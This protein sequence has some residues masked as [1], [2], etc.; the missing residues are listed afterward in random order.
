MK[1]FDEVAREGGETSMDEDLATPVLANLFNKASVFTVWR[2]TSDEAIKNMMLGVASGKGLDIKGKSAKK[3]NIS[4]YVPFIQIYED[5]HKDYMRAFLNDGR[6]VRVFYHSEEA[7]MEAL[8]MIFDIKEYMI[9]SA[10]D[11]MDILRNEFAN[12][13]D[14][15]LAM[16][17]LVYDDTN[18]AVDFV[19]T[20]V[21]SSQPVFG[22]DISERLFWESYVT[23]QD[24]SRPA[25]TEWDIGRGS[26]P[27]YMDKNFKSI[28]TVAKPGEPK[29]VVWQMSK[30]SPMQ[31]R[32]LLIAYEEFGTVKPVV[33]D[34]DCF[35][36]GSRG[37]KYDKP[38]SQDQVELTKWTVRNIGKV[39]DDRATSG[40]TAGWMS[41]WFK[42]QKNAVL[43]GYS[44]K[45]PPYGHGDP[46]SYDI[47]KVAVSRLQDT[48]CVRHGAECFN[49]Y[50]P[51]DIDD[52]FLVISDTLPGNVKWKKVNVEELQE[53]LIAKIDEGFTFPINPKWVLCDAGWK[54]VYNKLLASQHPNV[55]DSLNCWF[56][57][58]TRL[59]E[60]I[61]VISRRHPFGFESTGEKT[62]GTEDMDL[63]QDQ[64]ESLKIKRAW[65]KLRLMIY[66]ISFLKEKRRE[67]DERKMPAVRTILMR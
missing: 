60:K 23:M 22:L 52:V 27:V 21:D 25:N 62:E 40:S 31:P 34:F 56:P 30:D 15:E 43:D 16:K 24:C 51:Q 10:R 48:G 35:L 45:T 33:S 66:W 29:V 28:R 7:R 58:E 26:E 9:F 3:G 8:E 61:E 13:D 67:R 54:R 42:V 32:T 37:V 20:Y 38:I 63:L 41:T 55:Q 5:E 12:A 64:L 11:A 36:L 17:N 65:R 1:F 57:R 53:I 18:L 46:T 49:L 4:S 44:P 6:V 2:P 19:N 39:L 50:T 59:R 47:V 14:Q